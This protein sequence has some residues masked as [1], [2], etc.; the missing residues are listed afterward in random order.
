MLNIEK[1]LHLLLILFWVT[2]T[3]M[4]MKRQ[5][6]ESSDKGPNV[7]TS[8]SESEGAHEFKRRKLTSNRYHHDSFTD[9]PLPTD[10]TTTTS[11][12][13]EINEATDQVER[14]FTVDV[15]EP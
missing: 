15:T 5:L 12:A 8:S 4:A 9:T 14:A 11:T 3:A 2:S 7:Q 6:E 10:T 1:W 13:K